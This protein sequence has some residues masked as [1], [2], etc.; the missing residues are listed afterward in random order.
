M[1]RPRP[2]QKIPFAVLGLVATSMATGCSGGTSSQGVVSMACSTSHSTTVH[3][4]KYLEAL[5]TYV[6]RDQ[7]TGKSTIFT[8]SPKDEIRIQTLIKEA[9]RIRVT[10]KNQAVIRKD[11]QGKILDLTPV[12]QVNYHFITLVEIPYHTLESIEIIQAVK[13]SNAQTGAVTFYP[14][15][16]TNIGFEHPLNALEGILAPG[17]PLPPD[18]NN[19]LLSNLSSGGMLI[20]DISKEFINFTEVRTVTDDVCSS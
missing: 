10:D 4:A 12:N 7:L 19:Y 20:P 1:K 14:V 16:E 3:D 17:S 2:R 18:V 8:L 11:S 5:I 9:N 6:E 15:K 13:Q